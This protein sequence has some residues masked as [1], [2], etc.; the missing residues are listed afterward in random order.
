MRGTGSRPVTLWND[1]LSVHRVQYNKIC[2]P[3]H[4]S[5]NTFLRVGSL[6]TGVPPYHTSSCSNATNISRTTP[7]QLHAANLLTTGA[8]SATGHGPRPT[9][10]AHSCNRARDVPLRRSGSISCLLCSRST[11][12]R[13]ERAEQ[14]QRGRGRRTIWPS[15][16]HLRHVTG[17][18]HS[19]AMCPPPPPARG[20]VVRPRSG[21]CTRRE[22][23]SCS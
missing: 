13:G 8:S 20:A 4:H 3:F 14:A 1:R 15:S 23:H 21:V 17:F 18:L 22:T 6:A 7:A 9:A 5:G 11:T 2:I 10:A 19:D 12:G 16:P